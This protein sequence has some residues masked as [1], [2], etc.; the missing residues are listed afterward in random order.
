MIEK[1]PDVF[2]SKPMEGRVLSFRPQCLDRYRALD[3]YARNIQVGREFR[4]GFL[5]N[6]TSYEL[7]YLAKFLRKSDGLGVRSLIKPVILE[8]GKLLKWQWLG[9]AMVVDDVK[10]PCFEFFW[11]IEQELQRRGETLVD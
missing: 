8:I 5:K 10:V 3:D 6:L 11:E 1:K 4:P 9:K 2:S 7:K